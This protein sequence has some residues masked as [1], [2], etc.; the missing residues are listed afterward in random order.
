M[1]KNVLNT[2][3]R[4]FISNLFFGAVSFSAY[5]GDFDDNIL[6]FTSDSFLEQIDSVINTAPF[7]NN[8]YLA[9]QQAIDSQNDI[10]S[11][12]EQVFGCSFSNLHATTLREKT[13]VFRNGLRDD[14]LLSRHMVIGGY[15]MTSTEY[16]AGQVLRALK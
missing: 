7:P 11:V 12:C 3:R 16:Y 2:K 1:K 15:V 14:A 13:E 5:A 9:S 4:S 8:V 6:K 10:E